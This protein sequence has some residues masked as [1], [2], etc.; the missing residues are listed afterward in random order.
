MTSRPRNESTCN[1][2]ALALLLAAWNFVDNDA[3]RTAATGQD[4]LQRHAVVTVE[5]GRAHAI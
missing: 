2:L 1:W 3:V 5:Y 4:L